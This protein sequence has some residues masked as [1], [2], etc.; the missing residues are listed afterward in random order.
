MTAGHRGKQNG[1]IDVLFVGHDASRT[2]APT[3]LLR[4]VRW[5]K[6]NTDLRF[7]VLLRGD[8]PM[9]SDYRAVSHT[10]VLEQGIVRRLGPPVSWMGRRHRRKLE[11]RIRGLM[12]S[13]VFANSAASARALDFLSFLDVPVIT[14][15]PE[16]E[17]MLSDEDRIGRDSLSIVIE[18]SHLFVA[19]SDAVRKNLVE[20]HNIPSELI[21]VVHGSI[22]SAANEG[23]SSKFRR[24]NLGLSADTFL[25]GGVGTSDWRKG[26]DLFIQVARQA[27]N[28]LEHPA[29]FV[30]LGA[31]PRNAEFRH[32]QY[33][34]DRAG[35]GGHVHFLQPT[36]SPRD[37]YTAI[38]LLAMTSREDPFPLVVLE[39]AAAGKPTVCFDQAG[40]APEFVEHDCGFVVPYLDVHRMA[41]RITELLNNS[42][43]RQ[44]LGQNAR[45]KV[46]ERN[47]IDVAA[48]QVYEL[49]KRKMEDR[50]PEGSAE[51]RKA[52]QAK[53]FTTGELQ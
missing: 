35:L 41:Q 45:K 48:S 3:S 31:Q 40:G 26:P 50:W 33:D 8:G 28:Q 47:T 13:V 23:V 37:F 39:A 4:L 2:G 49:I 21:T 1:Q 6:L 18:R 14:R 34:I 22:D 42:S 32:L 44:R 7:Q 17:M 24:D 20:H 38:D 5:F 43:L 36:P 12:P 46:M 51:K 10:D 11:A 25:V 15:I 52:A 29:Q 27:L 16:L 30:W 53:L 9:L 19:A